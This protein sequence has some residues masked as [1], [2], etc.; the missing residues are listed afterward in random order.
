MEIK[1]KA[2]EIESN[3]VEARYYTK[4]GKKV[5]CSLCRHG[6]T[7]P[8]G[9]KGICKVRENRD[10][11]LISLVYGKPISTAIDPIEKKPIFH[12][13][14]GA[15]TLSYSTCGC[16]FK[17]SF[18]QNW[19]ISQQIMEDIEYFPPDEMIFLAKRKNAE[20]IAHTYTEPTI[21]F[22]YAFDIAKL[23]NKIGMKNIFVTNGYIET[24]PLKDISPYLD[25]A[26]IDLKTFNDRFYK[27]LCGAELDEVLKSIK[28]YKKLGI[29][30][31]L[32]NLIIPGHNDDMEEIKQMC[33]WIKSNC[34]SE[35]PLHFSRYFSHHKMKAPTTSE[36][37]LMKAHSIAKETGLRYVYIGNISSKFENTFCWK[38]GNE[39]INRSRFNIVENHLKKGRCSKCDTK[40]DIIC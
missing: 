1:S 3:I 9:K 18:C 28:S 14:P 10:G 24:N 6:C 20:I 2:V 39:V 26:N 5:K 8:L 11:K 19:Q 36:N 7:I 21:F 34:G 4:S 31:E 23:S 33:E 37:T 29:W 16:N 22:E 13:H 38:C 30:I 15:S 27:E 32:T 17:C 12:F 35:T 40:I 25:A